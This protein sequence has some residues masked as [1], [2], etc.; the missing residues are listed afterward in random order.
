METSR[1]LRIALGV[2]LVGGKKHVQVMCDMTK[3]SFMKRGHNDHASINTVGESQTGKTYRLY[4]HSETVT[5][6]LT[7]EIRTLPSQ[8]NP[9][10]TASAKYHFLNT[11]IARTIF[12]RFLTLIEFGY[13]SSIPFARIF[14]TVLTTTLPLAVMSLLANGSSDFE[15]Y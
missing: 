1:Q 2:E 10:S 15:R 3:M 12:N 6:T 4:E 14:R 11:T 5:L 13:S 7:H 9:K 8:H